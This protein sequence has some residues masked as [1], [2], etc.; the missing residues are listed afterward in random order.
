MNKQERTF[1]SSY[2][3]SKVHVNPGFVYFIK[4]DYGV[5]IG[6]TKNLTDRLNVFNVKLPFKI[7]L[8][9]FV[10]VIEYSKI[11]SLLHHLLSHKNINGEWFDLDKNDFIEIDTILN[12]INLKR[13]FTL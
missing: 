3:L 2:L 10:R 7:E 12:N 13:E 5:K 1:D 4:S 8:E 6:C 11:E 9:S